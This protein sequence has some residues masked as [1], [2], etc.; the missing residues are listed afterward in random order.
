MRSALQKA[1]FD[2]CKHML[3]NKPVHVVEERGHGRVK[4]W[5]T[6]VTDA[7]GIDFPHASQ[8]ACIRREEF[9]LDGV[10][11]SKE[12]ALVV[13]SATAGKVGSADLHTYVRGHWSIENK[14]HYVRDTTWR[15]DDQQAHT[16]NG[17]Q[18]IA[19]IR[20]LALGLFRLNG[21]QEIK[22][23]TRRIC[24]DRNRALPLLAT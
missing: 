21:M 15:E 4:R 8:V 13:T 18:V 22:E 5:S 24:R 14:G 9:D 11:I 12:Y 20:N 19:A 17:P 7:T 6:W 3:K 2:R 10:R 23:S 1:V 16:G